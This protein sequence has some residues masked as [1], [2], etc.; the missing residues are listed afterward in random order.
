METDVGGGEG[1]ARQLGDV[2]QCRGQEAS[3]VEIWKLSPAF[4]CLGAFS[5]A[6]AGLFSAPPSFPCQVALHSPVDVKNETVNR[7]FLLIRQKYPL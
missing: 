1:M 4:I 6:W 7:S 2:D 5:G 3:P